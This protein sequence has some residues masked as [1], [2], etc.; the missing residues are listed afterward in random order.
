MDQRF[1]KGVVGNLRAKL[2]D[3]SGRNSL[4]SFRHSER[5]RK[6]VRVV[7]TLLDRAF[8]ALDESKSIRIRPLP[9]PSF[10]P[11]D[12]QTPAFAEALEQAKSEDQTY[13]EGVKALGEK[14]PT[15]VLLKLELELRDRLRVTLGMMPVRR[16]KAQSREEYAKEL[17]IAPEYD[18]PAKAAARG[19]YARIQK[20]FQTILY[21][22]ELERKLSGIY[23][24]ARLSESET[25]LNTLYFAFGFL[26]WYESEDSSEPIYS[27]LA[28]YPAAINREISKGEYIYTVVSREDDLS[29]NICLL[30]RLKQD[31]SIE[32]LRMEAEELPEHYLGRF[33]TLIEKRR[34]WKVHRFITLSFFSFA[35][36]AMYHDLESALSNTHGTDSVLSKLI[37]GTEGVD[38]PFAED[39]EIDKPDISSRL[40]DIITDADSSQLSA[41]VDVLD[42][43]NLVIQGPPG[44]GKSQT[45]TNIIASAMAAGKSILFVAEKRAA[46]EVVKKR[47]DEARL[48]TFCLE[49]HSNKTRKTD[50]LASLGD[51]LNQ[52]SGGKSAYSFDDALARRERIKDTLGEYVSALN[53]P[54]GKTGKPLHSILWRSL[55]LRYE[56]PELPSELSDVILENAPELS[57]SDIETT[58]AVLQALERHLE[59]NLS[60]HPSVETHPWF[61]LAQAAHSPHDSKMLQARVADGIK[62]LRDLLE[63]AVAVPHFGRVLETTT[64][65]ELRGLVDSVS[66]NSVIDQSAAFEIAHS[67]SENL[68]SI[69]QA[70]ED[71]EAAWEMATQLASFVDPDANSQTPMTDLAELGDLARKLDLTSLLTTDI[72]ALIEHAQ[73]NLD[74]WTELQTT[75]ARIA[76]HLS[77]DSKAL[78]YQ[79]VTWLLRAIDFAKEASPKILKYRRQAILDPDNNAPIAEAVYPITRLRAERDFLRS[80]FHESIS[81]PR[82][83]LTAAA[84]CLSQSSFWSLFQR[85]YW[86]ACRLYYSV[87][88]SQERARAHHMGQMLA[89]LVSFQDDLDRLESDQRLKTILGDLYQGVD[90]NIAGISQMASWAGN[91]IKA[92]PNFDSFSQSVRK[93]LFEASPTELTFLR[94]FANHPH[95]KF[96]TELVSPSKDRPRRKVADEVSECTQR[97]RELTRAYALSG[98]LGLRRNLKLERVEEMKRLVAERDRLREALASEK[99]GRIL[100]TYYPIDHKNIDRIRATVALAN[101]LNEL[102]LPSKWMVLLSERD[103]KVILED[104]IASLQSLN[105]PLSRAEECLEKVEALRYDSTPKLRQGFLALL[106]DRFEKAS[107]NPAA[108]EILTDYLRREADALRAGAG[109]ILEAYKRAKAP[110]KRVTAAYGL[111]AYDSILKAAQEKFPQLKQSVSSEFEELRSRFVQIENQLLD[112]RRKKIAYELLRRRVD[113]GVSTGK[114]SELTELGLITHERSK[115]RKHIPIRDLL[116]RAGVAIRQMKPCL[117]MSPL[118]VAQFLSG[119]VEFDL[120]IMDEASQL[121][122]EDALGAVMRAKQ[123]VIVGD[124]KQLPPTNFFTFSDDASLADDAENKDLDVEQESILDWAF[125]SFHPARRLRWHYRSRH[126]SLIAFSNHMF[127]D[128][129]LIIFPSP[130]HSKE[131]HGIKFFPVKGLYD[132]R[133]NLPEAQKIVEAVTKLMEEHPERSIGIVAMNQEQRDLI[134]DLIDAKAPH[135]PVI[136]DYLRKWQS[137][138][139]PFF[140]KNLENVQG[141][142]RD[143]IVISTVYGKDANGNLFQRFGPV[144]GAMGHRRLN[145]LF[146]RAKYQMLVFSSIEPERLVTDNKSSE[147]LRAFRAF[148]K[149]AKEGRLDVAASEDNT[150]GPESDFEIF[151]MRRLQDRGYQVV[152]QVGVA[153]YFIDLAVRH[154]HLPG[155]YALGIECDG[156]TYHSAKC[157]RDRDKT[158]QEVLENLGWKIHRIW[159]TDW[160]QHTDRELARVL[161]ALPPTAT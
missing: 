61:G 146:T 111:V 85:R 89:R 73:K 144:N 158:R 156:A 25:G 86:A 4:I 103:C 31:F 152:P 7:D 106:I 15:K 44:T 43:K 139:E 69:Q 75:A 48:G 13:L 46:L 22:D 50:V 116:A 60:D 49:L 129:D 159:S 155:E 126:E 157:A 105:A 26:E 119:G 30:E 67:V 39:Y 21:P 110:L 14:R 150:R 34:G 59:A 16:E 142:E 62:A 135:D 83:E 115:Q 80:V 32:P 82:A 97:V 38:A 154:P 28:L 70:L 71:T 96:F 2:L 81:V 99:L 58:Q 113:R 9:L 140:V 64:L 56:V 79:H 95:R 93:W 66:K 123:V 134:S 84:L 130:F 160:F 42:G 1:V 29:D 37:E 19:R 108:L 98:S 124:P 57:E 52:R 131:T 63:A 117:M 109:P 72:P 55:R 102:P 78:T 136:Q 20:E 128:Q 143:V 147:G 11:P 53:A 35:K 145:V 10:E 91:V 122:P 133:K 76:D 18:L 100:A 33:E 45:I 5:A 112:L 36:L 40:Q 141:D 148:L 74:D 23:E 104:V 41:I 138:L 47:L 149:F 125:R 6:Q 54:F 153:G 107:S 132:K 24:Q 77:L 94:K 8:E 88:V 12:E 27:P 65:G 92:L 121:R 151:V 161:A 3:L 120:V 51:W 118:S 137:S 114:A 68:D 127:Y 87:S 90:S 17:G 101:R